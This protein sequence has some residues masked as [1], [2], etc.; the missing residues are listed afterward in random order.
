[1]NRT[2]GT[3]EFSIWRKSFQVRDLRTHLTSL[4]QLTSWFH[5]PDPDR[6]Y[7]V[8]QASN[9]WKEDHWFPSYNEK[10]SEAL[11]KQAEGEKMDDGF[12][13]LL[14]TR[15][16]K[17]QLDHL[18]TMDEEF[19]YLEYLTDIVAFKDVDG[20]FKAR[21]HRTGFRSGWLC[22]GPMIPESLYCLE[23]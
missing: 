16:A 7:V 11:S 6:S 2:Y 9:K 4:G 23:W 20:N 12:E 15:G 18:K 21:D 22:N 14:T 8:D 10:I 5:V 13:K 19:E 17:E 3:W 1:M